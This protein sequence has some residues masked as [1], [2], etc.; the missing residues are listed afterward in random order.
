MLGL[1]RVFDSKPGVWVFAP[2]SSIERVEYLVSN[3]TCQTQ[4]QY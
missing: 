4:R 3:R 2:H 1:E